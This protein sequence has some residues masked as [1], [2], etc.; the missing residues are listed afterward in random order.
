VSQTSLVS[1]IDDDAS[2]RDAL[3]GFLRVSGFAAEVFF[4]AEEFLQSGRLE[5]TSCLITDV[6]LPGSR[7]S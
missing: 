1:C 3:E 4:S 2:I 5:R 7:L 6:M